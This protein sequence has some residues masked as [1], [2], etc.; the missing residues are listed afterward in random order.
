KFAWNIHLLS[1][2]ERELH[3]EW[4]LYITHGFVDQSNVNVF[5]RSIYVTLVARRSCKYAG[6]RFLKRGAN[7]Q[8]D[9]ANEVETEQMVFDSGVSSLSR[10]HFTSFVQMRGSIPGHWSQDMGK[11]VAKPAISIDLCDPYAE[12]AAAH[13]NELLKRYGAPLIILNL[14]KK[15]EKKPQEKL[16]SEELES[17][18]KYLNQFLSPEHQILYKTFD[19]ARK[20]KMGANKH[21]SS[22]IS[23]Q[24][25]IIR[26][27]CV[28]CLDRTN[29]AQFAIGKYVLGY[30]L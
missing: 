20:N 14:V 2:A 26:T 8:G 22:E 10:G 18:I 4:I 25:G 11:M 15:H 7:F 28:D 12:I 1:K 24:T 16:L 13:F 30:Q 23:L 3:P 29:T 21:P 5:G 27:N 17:A 19:M 6:T 9:V